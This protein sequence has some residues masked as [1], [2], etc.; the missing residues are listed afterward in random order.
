MLKRFVMLAVALTVLTA[1]GCRHKCCRD[2]SASY[3]P[4]PPPPPP[5][6]PCR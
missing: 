5:C 4:P 2:T 1:A 3:A 6:D